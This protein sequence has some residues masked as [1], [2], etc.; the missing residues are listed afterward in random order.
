MP[1]RRIGGKS[2]GNRVAQRVLRS[3]GLVG[4]SLGWRLPGEA[5]EQGD[6][7]G[8]GRNAITGLRVVRRQPDALRWVLIDKFALL[9]PAVERT[10]GADDGPDAGAGELLGEDVVPTE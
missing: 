10:Q 3:S 2:D 6:E 8:R 7:L 4:L 5:I 1:R 9:G